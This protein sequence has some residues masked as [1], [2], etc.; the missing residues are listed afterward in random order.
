M[1]NE[2]TMR[3]QIN[4]RKYLLTAENYTKIN[5]I[6]QENQLIFLNKNSMQKYKKTITQCIIPKV[7][8]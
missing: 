5:N 3:K 4:G 6:I 2:I 1:E 8:K 7:N